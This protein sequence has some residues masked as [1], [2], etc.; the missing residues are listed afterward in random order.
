M[1]KILLE[2]DI[3]LQSMKNCEVTDIQKKSS[4]GY[5]LTI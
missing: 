5:C 2:G 1:T 3:K 4:F